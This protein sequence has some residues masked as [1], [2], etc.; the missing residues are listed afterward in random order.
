MNKFCLKRQSKH[1]TQNI[2]L[3]SQFIKNVEF[4]EIN[5]HSKIQK[6]LDQN[7]QLYFRLGSYA[8]PIIIIVIIQLMLLL[9]LL[10]EMMLVIEDHILDLPAIFMDVLQK[11]FSIRFLSLLI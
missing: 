8:A 6:V 2:F 9:L 4:Y 1:D 3:S 7:V 11:T 5:F 10:L